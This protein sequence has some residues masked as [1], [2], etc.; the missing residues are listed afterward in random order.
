MAQN[1]LKMGSFHL[2]SH[3]NWSGIIFRTTCFSSVF[4]PLFPRAKICTTGAL[5]TRHSPKM[6]H[7]QGILGFSVGQTRPP[8]AP[9]GLKT[10]VWAYQVVLT[11]IW[12]RPFFRPGDPDGPTVG[13]DDARPRLPYSSGPHGARLQVCTPCPWVTTQQAAFALGGTHG[14]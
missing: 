11:Q 6:A 5:Q 2:F 9:N 8:W 4:D 14:M 3:P 13:A 12:K 10:L 7:F 1:G